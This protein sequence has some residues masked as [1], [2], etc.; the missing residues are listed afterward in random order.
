MLP[1]PM[2][3]T[4]PSTRVGR[5]RYPLVSALALALGWLLVLLLSAVAPLLHNAPAALPPPWLAVGAATLVAMRQRAWWVTVVLALLLGG[6]GWLI[7]TLEV[8]TLPAPPA[9]MLMGL[10]ASLQARQ[11][12]VLTRRVWRD[13]ANDPRQLRLRRMAASANFVFRC[14]LPS[15]LLAGLVMA[16]LG[17]LSFWAGWSAWPRA[18]QPDALEL[19]RHGALYAAASGLS[20]VLLTPAL[21]WDHW[22]L[23]SWHIAGA[24]VLC[25]AALGSVVVVMPQALYAAPLLALVS[26]YL[27]GFWLASTGV[28]V[29]AASLMLALQWHELALL[30]GPVGFWTL[31]LLLWR[32]AGMSFLAALWSDRRL[33][34]HARSPAS[35]SDQ[36]GAQVFRNVVALEQH[37]LTAWPDQ[38]SVAWLHIDLRSERVPGASSLFAG[39]D[40]GAAAEP[41]GASTGSTEGIES[42]GQGLASPRLPALM[43]LLSRMLRNNDAVAPITAEALVIVLQNVDRRHLSKIVDRID[44]G[45]L[46]EA[47]RHAAPAHLRQAVVLDAS[48]LA[49]LLCSARYLMAEA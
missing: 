37:S 33:R 20:T 12:A 11:S 26:G 38:A 14:V 35:R 43:L 42:G 8:A 1:S 22:R 23:P 36:Q 18:P 24:M 40:A 15:A 39:L 46:R 5:R 2:V 41:E 4:A 6:I 34:L 45:L 10:V 21:N 28:A 29:M 44:V 30:D 31:L 19:L 32:L 27:G 25:C 7:R 47:N 3:S 49:V 17:W 16:V 13:I 9:L 48:A